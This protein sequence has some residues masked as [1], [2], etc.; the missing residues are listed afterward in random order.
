MIKNYTFTET[1][2]FVLFL[3]LVFSSSFIS[4]KKELTDVKISFYYDKTNFSLSKSDKKVLGETKSDKL[5]VRFYEVGLKNNKPIPF[6]PLLGEVFP[7]SKNIIPVIF[8]QNKVLEKIN[9]SSIDTLANRMV[10]FTNQICESRQLN[11]QEIQF[12]YDWTDKTKKRYF[13]FLEKYKNI[14]GKKKIITLKLNQLKDLENLNPSIVNKVILM[15]YDI[16]N[17]TDFSDILNNRDSNLQLDIAIPL[18]RWASHTRKQKVIGFLDKINKMDFENQE[19]F[20]KIDKNN[21]IVKKSFS[22]KNIL[23]KEGD[24]IKVKE[25]TNNKLMQIVSNLSKNRGDIKEIIFYNLDS[26][27][28]IKYGSGIFSKIE[29]ILNK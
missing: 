27:H 2:F 5:Y 23:F 12:N 20:K 28:Y 22:E 29:Q 16:D 15:Y 4:C 26:L 24:I 19:L 14:S 9:Y 10:A 21:F 17:K 7:K 13:Y 6:E 8:I 3:F 18:Y 11:P 1:T 25:V